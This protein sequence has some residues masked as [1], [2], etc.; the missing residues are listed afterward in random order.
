MCIF[1]AEM[2][3]YL[4]RLR[5]GRAGGT[6]RHAREVMQSKGEMLLFIDGAASL[7][8]RVGDTLEFYKKPSTV[9]DNRPR[10]G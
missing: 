9:G 4:F 3:E 7:D 10:K 5:Q 6:W 1:A 2:I 8:D